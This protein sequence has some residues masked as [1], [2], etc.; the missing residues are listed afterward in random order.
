MKTE[1]YTLRGCASQSIKNGS[2][3]NPH[4]CNKLNVFNG[5]QD[6]PT[7]TNTPNI[8]E[9]RFKNTRKAFFKNVNKLNLTEGDMVAVEASPGHDIGTI[10]LTGELVREQMKKKGVPLNSELKI[11]YRKVKP[12]DIEK[13]E[14]ATARE[15]QIMLQTRKIP[16]DLNLKMKI[17]DVEFQGDGNKA[18]FYYI[19]DKRVDFRELIRVL[20]SEFGIRI[21]MRQIGARQEAGIIGG[22]GSCGRELCCSSWMSN[23]VSVS[24]DSAREQQLSMNPQKLAGQCGKLKCCINFEKET[25]KD[26]LKKFPPKKSLKTGAGT[27]YFMK[28]DV[29]K[30]LVW[31]SFKKYGA[32]NVTAISIKRA[33]EVIEMNKDGKKPET[34]KDENEII[35]PKN[36]AFDFNDVVGQENIT[37]FDN[38]KRKKKR[39]KNKGSNNSANQKQQNKQV[40]KSNAKVKEETNKNK[41]NIAPRNIQK[42]NKRPKRKFKPRKKLFNKNNDKPKDDKKDS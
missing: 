3:C 42:Q 35:I 36:K 19:S 25:Y 6:I 39:R 16:K 8:V 41:K 24:T 4:S 22:I 31:Y 34:L 37:R 9:I 26:A 1:D 10:S 5:L 38:K 7:T 12:N 13:W 17:G 40:N 2:Y 27:A 21:E 32:E 33:F 28:I 18:I 11:I 14:E 23:F 15:N 29:F 30:E 20:A